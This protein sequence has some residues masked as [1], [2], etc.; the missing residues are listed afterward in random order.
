MRILA[1]QNCEIEGFGLYEKYLID[2]AI[3]HT[4]AHAY[5]D[6][7]YPGIETIDAILVGGTPISA[8][9]VLDHPFLREECGYL[10]RAFSEDVPCLGI[11]FGAQ[12]LAQLLGARIR[13]S[14]PKEIGCYEVRSTEQ[15]QA[16]PLLK[17]FPERFPVFQWHGDAFDIPVGAQSL[18]EGDGC[19]NQMFRLRGIVGVQF[20]LEVTGDDVAGWADE[21]DRELREFGKSRQDVVR[22]CR[23]REQETGPL[24]ARLLRNF[25]ES[26]VKRHQLKRAQ[27]LGRPQ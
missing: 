17:G 9:D 16:D 8:R 2:N 27:G 1:I 13:L 18:V 19:R 4:V 12:L 15:G 20:H 7:S 3:E 6:H 24:A 5:R 26:V 22:E 21:Y 23:E 25:I 11:C 14:D 10:D